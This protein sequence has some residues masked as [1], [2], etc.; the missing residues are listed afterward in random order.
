MIQKVIKISSKLL[1]NLRNYIGYITQIGSY[2]INADLG[3]IW[4]RPLND[5]ILKGLIQ[6]PVNF[7]YVIFQ[8]TMQERKLFLLMNKVNIHLVHRVISL[9]RE[10]FGIFWQIITLIPIAFT[11][12]ALGSSYTTAPFSRGQ[13]I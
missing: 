11:I 3:I 13:S 8:Y 7:I 12:D 4:I 9:A 10:I 2:L 5:F 1:H 6:C